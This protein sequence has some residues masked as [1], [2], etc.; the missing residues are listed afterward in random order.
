MLR[1]RIEI[2]GHVLGSTGSFVRRRGIVGIDHV[3]EG[4]YVLQFPPDKVVRTDHFHFWITPLND[5]PRVANLVPLSGS[6]IGVRIYNE[7][8]R[9]A[10][11]DFLIAAERI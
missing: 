10:D 6:A 11:S 9:P 8:G 3:G 7:L 2:S 1:N 4:I 5:G